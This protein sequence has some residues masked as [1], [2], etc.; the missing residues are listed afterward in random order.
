MGL[1]LFG[2]GKFGHE[3]VLKI[4]RE[5]IDAFIDNNQEGVSQDG[6]PIISMQKYSDLKRTDKIVITVSEKYDQAIK[7]Q[8]I[9]EGYEYQIFSDFYCEFLK[10]KILS[11][12][13]HIKIYK[14]VINWIKEHSI[15]KEGII[16]STDNSISYPEVTGYFI[17]TLLRW[18][19]RNL[20]LSYAKWLI[21]IQKENGSWYDAYD[22]E[23]YIFDTGQVLKGLLAIRNILPE[24]DSSIIKGCNW[25]LSCMNEE[26]RLITPSKDAWGEDKDFC[27]EIIHIYCL[28]PIIEAG[29]ILNRLEYI[30]KAHKIWDFYKTNYYEKIMSFS[31]L[32]HF[33]AY[34]MEALVD[35]GEIKMAEE[36]M[37][38]IS[39]YQKASGAIPGLNNVD[40]VCSTG[41]FQ[42]A[43]VWFRLGN[44]ERGNKAF[45]YACKLQNSSGGWFG[46]YLS[47][48]NPD[49]DNIYFPYG[50]I[51]WACKYFLDALYFKN[52]A[53]FN[54]NNNIFLESIEKDDDRYV[55]VLNTIKSLGTNNLRVLDVGCGKGRYIKN[56]ISDFP[57]NKYF[58]VDLSSVVLKNI[59]DHRVEC[60]QGSLT[61]I[62]YQDKYFDCTYTCEALEH[63]IDINNA[64]SEMARVTRHG[65]K[66]VIVDKNKE[67]LGLLEI[68]E[69]EQWFGDGALASIMKKY[70][71]NV[72][73][74]KEVGY[75]GKQPDGLFNVWVGTVK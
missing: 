38:N 8:L 6:I 62:P 31:L 20:A 46:S 17:P 22:K 69:W 13:D 7:N 5:N 70:C 26:G 18:G 37:H 35:L 71:S 63:A 43:L 56:L 30:E 28:S 32:S 55:Y 2:A 73:I 44:I 23:A 58:A 60:K 49:E 41:L 12:V 65:G 51:S 42:L 64:I 48:D 66:I 54:S 75:E 36:A 74:I 52:I 11:R 40:W 34:L 3:A 10:T 29:E 39:K 47:E 9:K 19:Y 21:S 33:Y 1:I 59:V 45:S 68:G 25:I 50:E 61:C 27:D 24:V 15:D 4:G 16:V 53:E 72:Q 57:E 67:M 14:K